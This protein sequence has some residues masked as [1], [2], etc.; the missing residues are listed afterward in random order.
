MIDVILVADPRNGNDP[1]EASTSLPA[2]PRKGDEI[3]VW[4]PDGHSWMPSGTEAF[5]TVEGVIFSTFEPERIVVLVRIDSYDLE[6]LERVMRG[7]RDGAGP[8]RVPAALGEKQ[9]RT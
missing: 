4:D 3:T 1:I 8:S 2:L 7:V 5:L 6:E 9:K